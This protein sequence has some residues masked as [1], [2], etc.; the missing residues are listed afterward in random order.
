MEQNKKDE[1]S[2]V[3]LNFDALENDPTESIEDESLSSADE[4]KRAESE[5]T[6]YTEP[7]LQNPPE[8]SDTDE[9]PEKPK[10]APKKAKEKKP[11]RERKQKEPRVPPAPT[12]EPALPLLVSAILFAVSIFALITNTFIHRFSSELLSPVILQIV[13]LVI[14][15]YLAVMLSS[16]N[17]STSAQLKEIGCRVI[18]ADHVFFII[19]AALFTMC[20]SLV[21]TLA[22]GGATNA[23]RGITLLGTFTAGVNEFTVSAPYL[24][25][26]YVI[27]PA[28]AEEVLFRGVL[29]S[30]LEK[31]SFP[32]AAFISCILSALYSFSLGGFI[33][34]LFVSLMSVIVL[35]TTGSLV[36]CMIV[37]ALVNL[38][39]LFLEA[40]ISAYFISSLNNLL[41]IVTVAIAF[42]LS[43]TLFFSEG[44]RI[45]REKSQ[46]IASGNAKSAKK[47]LGIKR[48]LLDARAMLA[49]TPNLVFSVI[50]LASFTAAVIIRFLTL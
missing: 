45:F 28:I 49:Y 11:K 40:N 30:R 20:A 35:Y 8:D 42:S 26:T 13:A 43:A 14:P 39:K 41:L 17:K 16:S 22:L 31:I 1:L 18:R 27:I 44:A 36:A 21:L 15:S 24:I 10:R 23:A 38:Y 6:E 4:I 7:P 3:S 5:M 32:F 12:D 46:N 9:E 37:H 34:A 19:F 47:L 50:C 48:V 29:F 2:E 25:L 33:P